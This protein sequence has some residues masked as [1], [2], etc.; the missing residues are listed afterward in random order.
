MTYEGRPGSVGTPVSV[1]TMRF[2]YDAGPIRRTTSA[3]DRVR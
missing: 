2:S 3:T 1:A